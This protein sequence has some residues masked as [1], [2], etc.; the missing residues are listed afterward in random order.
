MESLFV[1]AHFMQVGSNLMQRIGTKISESALALWMNSKLGQD[2]P[3]TMLCICFP[4]FHRRGDPHPLSLDDL[5]TCLW[6][7]RGQRF[8]AAVFGPFACS[9]NTL[10]YTIMPVIPF[11]K[12]TIVIVEFGTG[13]AV[14]E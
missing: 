12:T 1:F 7:C 10:T 14:P 11:D 6:S 9:Q 2:V 8:L 4:A 13:H 3:V 5:T